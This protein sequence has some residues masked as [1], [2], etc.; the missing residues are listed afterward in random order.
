M[1]ESGSLGSCEIC[2]IPFGRKNVLLKTTLTIL[3]GFVLTCITVALAIAV[4]ITF[5]NP[6]TLRNIILILFLNIFGIFCCGYNVIVIIYCI[7]SYVIVICY[8]V[9]SNSGD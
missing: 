4:A 8:N 3:I 7:C 2:K 9:M 6:L 5:E 1:E